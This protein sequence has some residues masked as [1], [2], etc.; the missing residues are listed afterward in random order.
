V[1][2]SIAASVHL[3]QVSGGAERSHSPAVV[4]TAPQHG[5]DGFIC[6]AATGDA[7]GLHGAEAPQGA[8]QQSVQEALSA[9]EAALA[10][11]QEKLA[12][13]ESLPSAREPWQSRVRGLASL[14]G[15]HV[16]R[17]CGLH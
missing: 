15:C 14:P 2:L 4:A 7:G 6:R 11:A 10:E 17:P 8:E 3:H 16:G 13:V 1:Q 5:R 9:A 12:D